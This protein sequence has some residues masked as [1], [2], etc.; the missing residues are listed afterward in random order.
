LTY[1]TYASLLLQGLLGDYLRHT[2][3]PKHPH[4]GSPLAVPEP[5]ELTQTVVVR[6]VWV[7]EK[8][9]QGIVTV[10]KLQMRIALARC[11]V[12][13][14]RFRIL[15]ADILPYKHYSLAVIEHSVHLYN[16]GYLS[17][18]AVVWDGF[19]GEYAP[20][21]TTLHAWSEGLGAYWSGRC[22]GE[23]AYALPASRIVAELEIRIP[24]IAPL[25]SIPVLVNPQRCRSLQ[26]RERL[27][28]CRRF[29]K[30]CMMI[31]W[32]FCELNRL[33]VSWGTSFGF[34]FRT[35]ITST[36]F[37]RINSA[38]MIPCAK[39]MRKEAA[40]C[41]IRGRSPPGDLK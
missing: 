15:P 9:E 21:H 12:C 3:C 37:E 10:V 20:S 14:R 39:P 19:Y 41:P 32:C 29:E 34:G 24:E 8:D 38:D 40:A 2:I 17:L 5:L 30:I 16:Q 31:S 26:R 33:I 36:P 22:F 1:N 13:K 25:H 7:L 28:A 6:G 18:R 23:V 35:G 27:E 4:N 11:P